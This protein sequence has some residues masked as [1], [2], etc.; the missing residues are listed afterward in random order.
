[1]GLFLASPISVWTAWQVRVNLKGALLLKTREESSAY[2]RMFSVNGLMLR[3]RTSIWLKCNKYSCDCHVIFSFILKIVI[4]GD[5]APAACSAN[6]TL[7]P[8]FSD[9]LWNDKIVN[10]TGNLESMHICWN[11]GVLWQKLSIR[12]GRPSLRLNAKR[13]HPVADT[14]D[15]LLLCIKLQILR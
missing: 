7:L 14:V 12:K 2:I 3:N 13:R 11:S 1:M 8:S 5:V 6:S 9:W 15:S 4:S 10:Y